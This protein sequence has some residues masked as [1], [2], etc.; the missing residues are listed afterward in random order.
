M[1]VEVAVLSSPSLISLVVSVDVKQKLK[2]NKKKNSTEFPSVFLPFT[3]LEKLV[4]CILLFTQIFPFSR[5]PLGH[6]DFLIFN[7][8]FGSLGFS[9]FLAHNYF[10]ISMWKFESLGC[11]QFS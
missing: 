11:L 2:K 7:W 5:G 10:R 4:L 1:K 9:K 3:L 6:L 8:N